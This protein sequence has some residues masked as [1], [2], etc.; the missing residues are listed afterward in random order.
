MQ[1]ILEIPNISYQIHLGTSDKEQENTQEIRVTV[2]ITYPKPP[3]GC[4]SDKIEETVDYVRVCEDIQVLLEKSKFHLIEYVARE[5]Y[6][7]LKPWVKHNLLIKV[8]KVNPPH[9][10]LNKG[11]TFSYGDPK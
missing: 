8:F 10:L 2:R 7:K 1:S 3:R 9:P 11:A 6:L 5:I 4:S